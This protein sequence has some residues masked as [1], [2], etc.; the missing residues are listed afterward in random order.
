M[1]SVPSA[2][3]ATVI[4]RYDDLSAVLSIR[5]AKLIKN[6]SLIASDFTEKKTVQIA[7]NSK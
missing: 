4:I 3:N 5:S 1:I 6:L 7:R 2:M